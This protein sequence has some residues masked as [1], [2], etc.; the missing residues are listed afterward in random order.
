MAQQVVNEVNKEMHLREDDEK[1]QWFI[2]STIRL[3][4]KKI[5]IHCAVKYKIL[6]RKLDI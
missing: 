3:V 1:C 5:H 4:R 6:S 2:I